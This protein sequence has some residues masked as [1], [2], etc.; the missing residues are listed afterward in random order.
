MKILMAALLLLPLKLPAAIDSQKDWAQTGRMR[1]EQC[2]FKDAARAFTKALQFRP[3]DASLHLW[4]GRS[5]AR[6]AESA[7]LLT[8]SGNARHARKSYERAIELQPS[9]RSYIRELFDF[10]LDSPQWFKGGLDRAALLVP[11]IA[12]DDPGEQAFLKVLLA[13]ARQEFRG[14]DWRLRQALTLHP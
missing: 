6:M 8:A 4:L 1:F 7:T 11:R 12:P 3:D 9:D 14:P 13:D 2:E 10:Y 5:Y